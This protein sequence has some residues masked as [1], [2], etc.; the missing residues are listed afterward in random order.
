MATTTE[1]VYVKL[2]IDTTQFNSS[3]IGMK[4]EMTAL[5]GLIGNNL[6][7][8]QET[9][10]LK[11]RFGEIKDQ[12]IKLQK[13]ATATN[14]GADEAFGNMA[15]L[16]GVAAQAVAGVTGAMSLLGLETG[17][18]GEIEKKILQ[19]MSIGN[20]LQS[21]ADSKRLASMAQ[22]YGQKIKDLFITKQIVEAETGVGERGTEKSKNV[23][24]DTSEVAKANAAANIAQAA[25]IEKLGVSVAST[26]GL[27][28]QLNAQIALNN[29]LLK[30]N[31]SAIA[32]VDSELK[33]FEGTQVF[34]NNEL[35]RE[36]LLIQ[37]RDGLLLE[38]TALQ[39]K[40]V[41]LEEDLAVAR[42]ANT[43]ATNV[44]TIA[45]NVNIGAQTASIGVLGKVKNY[46]LD[47]A[48]AAW[49]FT[50][51]LLLNP[52]VI[53]IATVVALGAAIYYLVKALTTESETSKEAWQALKRLN[54]E[55]IRSRKIMEDVGK[56]AIDTLAP[57]KVLVDKLIRSINNENLSL[58][59][60]KK[61]LKELIA[62]DPKYLD[63]LTLANLNTAKGVGITD[64]YIKALSKKAEAMALESELVKLYSEKYTNSIEYENLL[65]GIQVNKL[66]L[67]K[68]QNTNK[69]WFGGEVDRLK[70]Q[71]K[72]EEELALTSKARLDN[73]SLNIDKLASKLGNMKVPE[74]DFNITD[75]TVKEIKDKQTDYEKWYLEMVKKRYENEEY[76]KRKNI[77][78]GKPAKLPKAVTGKLYEDFDIQKEY[79]KNDLQLSKDTLN[80]KLDAQKDYLIKKI[81][82]IKQEIRN[83]KAA[84]Q[85]TLKIEKDLAD[86]QIQLMDL[87]MTQM[88]K[89]KFEWDKLWNT[90][91]FSVKLQ[92]ISD[93]VSQA[94]YNIGDFINISIN[95]QSELLNRQIENTL[96]EQQNMYDESIKGLDSALKY[97][98]IS[99]EK[100][101]KLKIKNDEELA[102]KEKK[103]KTYQAQKEKEWNIER[104]LIAA[105]QSVAQALAQPPPASYF[106]AAANAILGAAQVAAIRAIPL[107]VFE[108]GGYIEGISHSQG[109]TL[110]NAETGEFIVNKKSAQAPNMRPVLESI[111]AGTYQGLDMVSLEKVIKDT[112]VSVASI[113]VVNV[114]S[115]S[116]KVQRKVANIEKKSSW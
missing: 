6:L 29:L 73:T 20:A 115:N 82:L 10:A 68:A 98:V 90:D 78:D 54:D 75:K 43:T 45:T 19:F 32:Q 2:Q 91:D 37:K 14:I 18:A 59:E 25:S 70:E 110:V 79:A 15:Q 4:K 109:G 38:Q 47:G 93:I 53:F 106:M 49:A 76:I 26:T 46:F 36:K 30:K 103:L 51:S 16:G 28:G 102:E 56:T 41:Q 95:K 89:W 21:V 3:I 114:E 105:A 61:K 71:I 99:Q 108:Q 57:Q 83:A 50:K 24:G 80:K 88:E 8:P 84:G 74:V 34:T 9:L 17:K 85:D 23:P 5:K 101:N 87:T 40:S 58:E 72:K 42:A 35:N 39:S 13:E 55:R 92:K 52:M 1:N 27:E 63:G 86:T 67:I 31:A 111:N 107:P 81:D 62:L 33:M 44:N 97:G 116:T 64:A 12:F 112:I 104:A 113:P 66:Q 100:Y 7:S 94:F 48:K 60:K 22:I 77:G 69:E 96:S 65:L 11:A